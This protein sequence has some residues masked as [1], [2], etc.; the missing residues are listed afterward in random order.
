MARKPRKMGKYIRGSVDEEL[1]LA[2]LAA[3]TAVAAIFDNVVADRMFVSSLVAIYSLRNFTQG[4]DDGPIMIGV[5]HSD[6]TSAEIEEYIES[7]GSWNEGNKKEQEVQKRQ[8]RRIGV[9]EV[10]V[11]ANE[12]EVLNHG[13]PIKTKL[14][15]IMLESQS[16]QLWAYNLGSS[17]LATTVPVVTAEGHANLW[18]R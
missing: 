14:N 12:V 4:V 10:A 16:L 7:T 8:I 3:K 1:T 17:A 2:T 5:A 6:Y 9:F 11:N 13:S 15:W 18:P